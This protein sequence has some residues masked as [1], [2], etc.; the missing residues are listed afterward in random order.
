MDPLKGK[1]ALITGGTSGIG[2]ATAKLFQKEGATVI[3]TGASE[4]SVNAAREAMPGIEFVH[5]NASDTQAA[6]HLIESVAQKHGRIDIL[7]VNAGIARVSSAADTE[8]QQFDELF[9]TNVRGPYFLLKRAIPVLSDGA[10][11]I[12][13]SSA[14]ALRGL[15]GLSAYSASKAALRSVGITLAVELASRKIRVNTIT[16]G[17]I[18]TPIAGKMGLTPA[19]MAG[20]GEMIARVPLQ[21]PGEPEEI[22]AAAFYFASD[23]SRFT[24]GTEL[25]IDG[26]LTLL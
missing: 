12:L 22:A 6:Q 8:E 26:G 9:A 2:A 13:T 21:R 20:F 15:P 11:V 16:P 18:N 17:P 14:G 24:T 4:K 19:Q 23:E 25:I 7:F 1:I 3:V 10:S 5:S